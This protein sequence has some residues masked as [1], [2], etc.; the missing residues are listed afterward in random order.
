M[1]AE[2]MQDNLFTRFIE[3]PMWLQA[4]IYWMM[5]LN[6]AALFFLRSTEGRVVLAV[7]ICNGITM[8]LMYEMYGYVRLLG[9][10]HVIWWTPLVIYLF[11]RRKAF[12]AGAVATWLW[13]LMLTNSASLVIDYI[14]VIR[15][16]MG[17]VAETG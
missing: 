2:M 1:I 3:L 16:F 9:L 12:P 15:F 13:V 10:S 8:S 11:R 7:W 17:D 6:T 14:D 5:L 4:W